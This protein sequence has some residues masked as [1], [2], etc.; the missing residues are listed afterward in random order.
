MP[1]QPTQVTG[2]AIGAAVIAATAAVSALL[3]LGVPAYLAHI[4]L[5]TRAV[6]A[7]WDHG[8]LTVWTGTN[9]PFA[10]RARLSQ[11]LGISEAAIRVIVPPVGGGF[12]GKHGDEAAEAARLAGVPASR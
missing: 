7:V 8:R 12:G 2:H 4:P 3:C 1:L 9:V 10:V 5:E 11:A 6:L